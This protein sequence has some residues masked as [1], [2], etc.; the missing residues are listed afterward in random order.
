MVLRRREGAIVR[1]IFIQVLN[2]F[3]FIVSTYSWAGT[4][5]FSICFDNEGFTHNTNKRPKTMAD[6]GANLLGGGREALAWFY[7]HNHY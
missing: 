6:T 7:P 2:Y 4:A 5:D 3:T 1:T